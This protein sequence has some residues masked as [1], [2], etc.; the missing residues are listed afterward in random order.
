M[1]AAPNHSK[2]STRV[3]MRETSASRGPSRHDVEPS[4]SSSC[5][6]DYARPTNERTRK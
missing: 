6:V 5:S 4:N 2:L 1:A 3:S